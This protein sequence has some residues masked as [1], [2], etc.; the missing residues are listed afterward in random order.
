M[1][2]SIYRC[3]IIALGLMFASCSQSKSNGIL[4]TSRE[5]VN[6]DTIQLYRLG[7]I[8][9]RTFIIEHDIDLKGHVC[10]LPRIYLLRRN[11]AL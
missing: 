6:P 4:D 8:E 2:K 1:V 11:M 9:N 5:M 7:R 10:I 3:Y